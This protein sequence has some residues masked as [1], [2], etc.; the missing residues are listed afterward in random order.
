MPR[1]E[2]PFYRVVLTHPPPADLAARCTET[3]IELLDLAGRLRHDE[4]DKRLGHR[5]GLGPFDEVSPRTG[6]SA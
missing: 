3:L 2:R 6:S 5:G 1:R 4:E